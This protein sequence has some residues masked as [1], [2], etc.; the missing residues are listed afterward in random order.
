M[1]LKSLEALQKNTKRLVYLIEEDISFMVPLVRVN[2]HLYV[3]WQE[4]LKSTC[5]F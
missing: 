4:S 3:A 1:T 5:V 2:H